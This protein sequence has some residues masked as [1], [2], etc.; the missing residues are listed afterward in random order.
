[1]L[2]TWHLHYIWIEMVSDWICIPHK[3][4]LTG[5]A[6]TVT[7]CLTD[8]TM[9]IAECDVSVSK[10][11]KFLDGFRFSIK[12]IGIKK[13]YRIRYWNF[14]GI[15]TLS[16]S[17]SE[18]F[19]IGK[20]FGFGFTHWMIVIWYHKS[21]FL[22][23]VVLNYGRWWIRI[24]AFTLLHPQGRH[25]PHTHIHRHPNHMMVMMM[26]IIFMMM[27]MMMMMMIMTSSVTLPSSSW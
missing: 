15:K 16:D 8:L 22:I 26:M 10:L 12:K 4:E 23:K 27:A 19:G 20:S 18:K 1:M 5:A 21:D 24:K 13:M 7:S 14:F 6:S 9:M 17:V 3:N 11:F 2:S 25:Q